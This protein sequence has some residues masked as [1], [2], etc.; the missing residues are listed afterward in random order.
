M[1]EH[2]GQLDIPPH[3]KAHED[4]VE[5][6]RIWAAAGKQDV[7]LRTGIWKD[8]AAWG[9]MLVDLAKHIANGYAQAEGRDRAEVLER[10]KA[11]LDA[12]WSAATDKPTGSVG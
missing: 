1:F 7:V 3:A 4:A 5:I 11:G 10:I 12:E 2:S 8:P 6:A 9:L